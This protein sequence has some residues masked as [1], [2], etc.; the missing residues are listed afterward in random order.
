MAATAPSPRAAS[1]PRELLSS[2]PSRPVG[3]ANR[4]PGACSGCGDW[5][6]AGEGR[7]TYC[8]EDGGCMQHFDSPGYHV[9]CRDGEACAAR[10]SAARDAAVAK[11][12]LARDLD[13][14]TRGLKNLIRAGSNGKPEGLADLQTVIM[15][16]LAGRAGGSEFM[17]IRADGSIIYVESSC[18]DYYEWYLPAL[19][20]EFAARLYAFEAAIAAAPDAAE[21]RWAKVEYQSVALA[22]E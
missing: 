13:Q 2:A 7:L 12:A 11:K 20:R 3:A 22:A 16:S 8:C 19:P 5:I 15:V 4:K 17:K 18:D 6:A 14:A 10:K 9:W 21:K 1:A